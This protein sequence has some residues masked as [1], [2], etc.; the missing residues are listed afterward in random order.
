MQDFISALSSDSTY[1]VLIIYVIALLAISLGFGLAMRYDE[2]V[3]GI[4]PLLW[5][6]VRAAFWKIDMSIFLSFICSVILA[7]LLWKASL[8]ETGDNPMGQW[9]FRAITCAGFISLT[10]NLAYVKMTDVLAAYKRATLL[11]Q[12]PQVVGEV[13]I[14]EEIRNQKQ[15]FLTLRIAAFYKAT[16]SNQVA[17]N[18]GNEFRF[19]LDSLDSYSSLIRK[20]K[21]VRIFYE[22]IDSEKDPLKFVVPPRIIHIISADSESK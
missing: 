2:S 20:A 14:I 21:R 7:S 17:Y 11:N 22:T 12:S 13:N 18:G 19:L 3:T 4:Q 15:I 9:F 8:H 6:E 5:D 10:A 1:V 16:M